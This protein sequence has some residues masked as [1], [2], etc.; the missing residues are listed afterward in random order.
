MASG[1]RALALIQRVKAWISVSLSFPW[2]AFAGRRCSG[3]LRPGGFDPRSPGRWPA[4]ESPPC[5]IEVRE[6]R[7][8]PLL[9]VGAMAP[10]A[11]GRQHWPNILLEVFEL[12]G[13]ASTPRLSTRTLRGRGGITPIANPREEKGVPTHGKLLQTSVCV[14]EHPSTGGAESRTRR[15]GESSFEGRSPLEFG[16]P[17]HFLYPM[18]T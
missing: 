14:E 5:I 13:Q 6:S 4:L 18:P 7:R 8:S 17:K 11:P 10:D 3:S 16:V 9:L 15:G 2:E 1:R 12:R